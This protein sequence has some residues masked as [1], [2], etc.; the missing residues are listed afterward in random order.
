MNRLNSAF[1]CSSG[2]YYACGSG[3]NVLLAGYGSTIT[4]TQAFSKH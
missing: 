2:V 1:L 4:I 3:E